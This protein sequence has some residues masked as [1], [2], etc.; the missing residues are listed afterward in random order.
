LNKENDFAI[1]TTLSAITY[2]Q[3]IKAAQANGY[4]VTIIFFLAQQY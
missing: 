3:T 1:E 4:Y 2:K